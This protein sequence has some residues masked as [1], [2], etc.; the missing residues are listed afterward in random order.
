MNATR[1][2]IYTPSQPSTRA[3]RIAARPEVDGQTV[4]GRKFYVWD[5]DRQHALEWGAEL[6]HAAQLGQR[7]RTRRSTPEAH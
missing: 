1:S 2:G 3:S 5:E 4:I 7:R 6:G